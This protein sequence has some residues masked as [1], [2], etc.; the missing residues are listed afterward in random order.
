MLLQH[1][2]LAPLVK[3]ATITEEDEEEAEAGGEVQPAH[4]TP[5]DTQGSNEPVSDKV[6]ADWVKEALEKRKNGTLGRGAPKPALHAAPLDAVTS[7]GKN[8]TSSLDFGN[9]A[10]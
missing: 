3:P 4:A 8:G 5:H 7:P 2:W 9:Q 1:A 10:G 6:V